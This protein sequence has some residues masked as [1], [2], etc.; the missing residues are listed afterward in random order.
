M[1]AHRILGQTQI[2]EFERLTNVDLSGFAVN[3]EEVLRRVDAN[4]RVLEA[5]DTV[6]K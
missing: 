2:V 1:D 4:K 3:S 5:L 6:L